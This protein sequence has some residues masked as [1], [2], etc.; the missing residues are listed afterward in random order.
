M[1][2]CSEGDPILDAVNAHEVMAGA[3]DRFQILDD[4]VKRGLEFEQVEGGFRPVSPPHEVATRRR[5]TP[6]GGG[7]WSKPGNHHLRAELPSRASG[8][9]RLSNGPVTI[10]V[11]PI[12]ARNVAGAVAG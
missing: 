8:V 9:M 1:S 10:E 5:R 6:A 3:R 7:Y 4:F 2:G 11:R 12:G